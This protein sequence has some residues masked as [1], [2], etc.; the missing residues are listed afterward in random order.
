MKLIPKEAAEKIYDYLIEHGGARSHIIDG[1]DVEK[2]AFVFHAS[3]QGIT[4]Y[5][6]VSKLGFGGKF[7][8]NM[9]RWYVSCYKE[10]ETPE[11][12]KL[13]EQ[14]NEF[15]SAL[16]GATKKKNMS[17]EELYKLVM[18]CLLKGGF[19]EDAVGHYM[20]DARLPGAADYA[21]Q[22]LWINQIPEDED[23]HILRKQL[24]YI[25]THGQFDLKE[26]L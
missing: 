14:I 24:M 11:R 4:E 10:D 18:R 16:Q 1:V 23:T 2:D 6:C 25:K 20:K 19:K 17:Y 13:I 26:R 21:A 7:W 22:L 5:R 9:D 3:E 15:L 12:K 8:N